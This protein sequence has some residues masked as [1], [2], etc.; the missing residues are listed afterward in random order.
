MRAGG[1]RWRDQVVLDP[2]G[3]QDARGPRR[4]GAR[5]GARGLRRVRPACS[6]LRMKR[7]A[8]ADSSCHLS[9]PSPR[10]VPPRP[11]SLARSTAD[12]YLSPRLSTI[13]ASRPSR[14][15]FPRSPYSSPPH[16]RRR[17]RRPRPLPIPF[18]SPSS[19]PRILPRPPARRPLP[20]PNARHAQ[21]GPRRRLALDL[22]RRGR[23]RVRGRRRRRLPQAL[24]GARQGRGQ[25]LSVPLCSPSCL[26]PESKMVGVVVE[27]RRGGVDLQNEVSVAASSACASGRRTR[28]TR[29]RASE[30]GL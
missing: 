2:V 24:R 22:D 28:A 11:A 4:G 8:R 7:R 3:P 21:L 1:D 5:Q 9:P 19:R 10:P 29:S 17:R 14:T 30:R 16:H 27:G 25:A 18:P 12:A 26:V 20:T 13:S 15:P 6:L 23:R